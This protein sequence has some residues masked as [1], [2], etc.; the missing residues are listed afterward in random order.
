[1]RRS[2]TARR[3]RFFSSRKSAIV[4]EIHSGARAVDPG[5]AEAEVVARPSRWLEI[6]AA[7]VALVFMAAYLILVLQIDLRRESAPGQIDARFWPTML[8]VLGVVIAGWRLVYAMVRPPADRDDLERMQRGG[9]RRLVLTV[10]LTVVYLAL[11][12]L[13]AVIA[14]G[15]SFNLFVFITPVFL[16]AL[17]YIYG[18]RSW[19]TFV[20][21]PVIT[22]AFIYVLF[23]MLLR[24]PL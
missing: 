19:K 4:T 18:A 17:L 3:T 2:V 7:G 10:A 12:E 22:T 15:Y 14:F 16:F 13:R 6:A 23:G 9:M 21:F 1:V 20:L 11:W 8:G 24:I 5:P